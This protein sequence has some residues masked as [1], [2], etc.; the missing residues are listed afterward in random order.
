MF[1]TPPA[2]Y[3]VRVTDVPDTTSDVPGTGGLMFMTPPATYQV[4]VSDAPDTISDVPGTCD[5]N[6]KK[7]FFYP[8]ESTLEQ[9]CLCICIFVF[10]VPMGIS[11]MGNSGRFPQGKPAATLQLLIKRMLGLFVF[12]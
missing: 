5:Y 6:Y 1:L 4:R 11:P 7:Q 10:C 3:Q 2:T 8:T 12:P 9:T